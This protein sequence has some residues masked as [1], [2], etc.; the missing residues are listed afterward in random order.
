MQAAL[1]DGTLAKE[2]MWHTVFLTPKGK[3]DLRGIGLVK[4]LWKAITSLLNFRLTA[5]ISFHDTLHGFRVGRGTRNVTL[6]AKL[7][8]QLT[9]TRKAVLFEVFLDIQKAYD[10]LD[11]ERSL[12]LLT[13][14]G[15][16]PRTVQLLRTY[17]D[18]LTMV[19]KAGGYFGRPFKGY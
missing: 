4:V 15:V 5:A 14:Y 12:G 13:A 9:A 8:Q 3:G 7:L 16:G 1:Q 6:E 18:Q 10:A 2:C 17:W 11:R 19:A